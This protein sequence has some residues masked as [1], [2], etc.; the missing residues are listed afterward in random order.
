MEGHILALFPPLTHERDSKKMSEEEREEAYAQLTT[1][2]EVRRQ[3]RKGLGA[4]DLSAS[5]AWPF[6]A[7]V[8]YAVSVVDHAVIDEINILQVRNRSS[9]LAAQ[10]T[11]R[12]EHFLAPFRL[13]CYPWAQIQPAGG[14][15]GSKRASLQA[16]LRG[17]E[18][19]VAGLSKR[20]DFILVGEGPDPPVPDRRAPHG[21]LA[22]SAQ[23]PLK[24]DRWEP[25][26]QGLRFC[27]G[28]G[29]GQGRLDLLRHR[30]RLGPRQGDQGPDH[31][32]A[33]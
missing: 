30:R 33:G 28:P 9:R 15:F 4:T 32:G 24:R 19:A 27:P 2:P 26:A 7:Q 10:V 11:E 22:C 20:P 14:A 13:R 23:T 1:H 12:G 5:A 18:E 3:Q 31:A 29:G 17:M 6:H 16:T 21:W 8:V 25:A